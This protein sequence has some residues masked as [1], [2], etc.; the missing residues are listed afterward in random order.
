MTEPAPRPGR[1]AGLLLPLFSC[2]STSSW[3]IG[4]FADV[5]AAAR[6]MVG[7]G[8]R[9]WQLLPL[10]EMAPGQSSPYSA[11]SAMALDPIFISVSQ[12]PEF[13]A[14]GGEG[15]LD[16]ESAGLLA[17]VRRSRR[18]EYRN[19][20]DLKERTLRAAFGRFHDTEWT[21]DSARSEQFRDFCR[22]QA[23]WLDDYSL[24]RALLHASGGHAWREW[25]D[26]IRERRVETVAQARREFEREQ[27]YRQYLQ[28]IAHSQWSAARIGARGMWIYGDFPFAVAADS[29]DVWA[30]Q[31]LFAF[32]GTVGAPPDAFSAEGQN[33][34]LPI[35]R[36]PM[37]A[38][39]G[40]DWL[41][42]RAR[43]AA[44]LF[45]GFRVDHVVGLFRTW[46]FPFDARRPHFTPASPPEQ[47]AQGEA[48]LRAIAA[49]GAD[50]I[51]EDLGTI[52]PFVHHVLTALGIPG[53][54]VFR[55]ERLFAR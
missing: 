21:R 44:D 54:K 19:V 43:R 16:A 50:I 40:Y 28:W 31:E 39:N 6:W 52:P 30:H 9:L 37:L 34:Q 11:I 4:E 48:V 17:H 51:A 1:M 24:Y 42:Q 8:L 23:W 13:Q 41:R 38:A 29:A 46:I 55:W 33:W 36:W 10:N 18:V 32:D 15:A 3:G 20:H 25:P 22:E 45:D 47:A 7:A 27:L 49:C 12:V 14:G 35:Y 2:P 26:A 53:Y 5:P